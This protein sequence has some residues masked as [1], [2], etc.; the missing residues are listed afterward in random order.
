[1]K[2]M[3]AVLCLLSG[4]AS[5]GGKSDA[6]RA[7]NVARAKLEAGDLPGARKSLSEA[8]RALCLRFKLELEIREVEG[9]LASCTTDADCEAK[10]GAER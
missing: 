5:A 7:V 3:V 10:F 9:V 1:M 6:K 8:K 4:V 2:K